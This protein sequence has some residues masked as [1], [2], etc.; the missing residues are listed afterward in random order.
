MKP[1][2]INFKTNKLLYN[3]IEIAL[4]HGFSPVNLQ[5]IFRTLRIIQTPVL[6]DK[7]LKVPKNLMNLKNVMLKSES[8]GSLVTF[9]G[10]VV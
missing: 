8:I 9:R 4:L 2:L 5:H 10:N 7:N 3:F 1:P 6:I